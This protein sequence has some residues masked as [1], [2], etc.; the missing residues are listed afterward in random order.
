M[1][2]IDLEKIKENYTRMSDSDLIY[3]ATKNAQGLQAEVFEIIENEIKRRNLNP[4]LGSGTI[5]QNK[6]YTVDE[7]EL[8]AELIRNLNCPSC[9]SSD[10]KLNATLT[11]TVASFLVFTSYR[12][13]YQIACPPCL[14][15]KNN[16]A[17]VSTALLG[18]WGFPWGLIKT[19]QYLY[20]NFKAKEQNKVEGVNP[21][22]LSYTA[23]KIGELEVYQG[24]KDKMQ[25]IISQRIH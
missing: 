14:N 3:V 4:N 2:G 16:R 24:D 12:S 20:K 17:M 8:Y 9:G 21:V 6:E 1:S 15:K 13:D 22:L 10:H 7:L 11:H 18:S 23:S 5:A 25:A 19:P